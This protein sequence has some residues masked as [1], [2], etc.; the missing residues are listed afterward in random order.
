MIDVSQLS[1]D[2]VISTDTLLADRVE[3][4][5]G[6]STLLYGTASLAGVVNVIGKPI[7]EGMPN[8]NFNY[9]VEREAYIRY[10]TNN[11]EKLATAGVIIDLTYNIALRIEGLSRDLNNYAVVKN[12]VLIGLVRQ[13][14]AFMADTT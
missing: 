10:N 3:L 9:K 14:T 7:P 4:V 2:H 1:P 12:I 5:R 13:A 11:K 8:G 6:L